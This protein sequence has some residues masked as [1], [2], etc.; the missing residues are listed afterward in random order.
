MRARSY[1][2]PT[3]REVP[4]EASVLSHQLMLRTGM[5]D[6]LASGLYSWLPLGLRALKVVST[7][8]R[9]EQ[10]RI[11]GAEFMTPILQPAAL[12]EQSGRYESYGK[13]LLRVEDRHDVP[14]LFGPTSEEVF[15]EI[16]SK[17]VRS[18][19]D[20]PKRF[21]QIQ[22]KLRD[23]IRPRFGV[24]RAREFFMKDLY[25]FDLDAAS[26]RKSYED[27][28]LSYLRIFKRLGV[29]VVIVRADTGPIGGDLSH[30]F[31]I[32]SHMG[33]SE[34]IYD[35]EFVEDKITSLEDLEGM[36]AQ[37]SDLH[38]DENCP[39]P[40]ERLKRCRGIEVG[41]IFYFG[42]KY[43]KA[44]GAL[45]MNQEGR[46][47]PVEMGSYGIG[48]GR[49][50]AALIEV[51][52]DER[53]IV[54]PETL[55]P[56]F[57]GLL[58]TQSRDTKARAFTETLYNRLQAQGVSVYYDDRDVSPGV[59]L[60]DL[61]LIGLPYQLI[62]NG[63]SISGGTL[64]VKSRKTGCEVAASQDRVV[65]LACSQKLSTLFV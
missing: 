31:H 26:A 23:E 47:V 44:L 35:A 8:V 55:A 18:Y 12:W 28:A 14:M 41:H 60:A 49:L 6:Q 15:T 54:W 4:Q 2:I 43:S 9:E 27:V 38:N 39:V 48:L 50:V 29:G 10:E 7:I 36:Y 37:T 46:Q 1:F 52:H 53:G 5:V 33:E 65:D 21:F 63:D 22:V 40:Q 20:L 56:F 13:E 51:F 61:D 62:V 25:S 32:V 58:N 17:H 34:L 45:V 64:N 3:K 59:K 57:C 30:E 16:F 42:T 24:M 11:G 19:K